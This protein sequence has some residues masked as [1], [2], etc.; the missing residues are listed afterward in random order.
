MEAVKSLTRMQIE[1]IQYL[2]TLGMTVIYIDNSFFQVVEFQ[3]I[4]EDIKHKITVIGRDITDKINNAISVAGRTV[5]FGE[6]VHAEIINMQQ[7]TR[8]FSPD[9]SWKLYRTV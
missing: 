3:P 7:Y 9:A 1:Y 5:Q 6:Q 2:N 8:E 4:D